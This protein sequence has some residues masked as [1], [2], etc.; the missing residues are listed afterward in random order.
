LIAFPSTKSL[1][2]LSSSYFFTQLPKTLIRTKCTLTASTGDI[3]FSDGNA[4]DLLYK[5]AEE[6]RFKSAVKDWQNCGH[7]CSWGRGADWQKES[8]S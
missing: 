1:I 2:H 3:Y 6:Q 7:A 8:K 5:C 4:N